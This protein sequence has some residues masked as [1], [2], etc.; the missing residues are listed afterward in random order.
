M[1]QHGVL[2]WAL[3][4][5][6]MAVGAAQ[7]AAQSTE[8]QKLT[9]SDAAANDSFGASVSVSGDTAIVGAWQD[10]CA[11]G[12]NCG[13]AYVYRFDGTSWVEQQKLTPFE[14]RAGDRFGQSVSVDGDTA[15]V[16]ASGYF[17]D[18]LSGSCGAAYV[19]RFDGTSWVEQQ[20]LLADDTSLGDL[21]GLA[22]S[23]SGDT[24]LVGAIQKDAAYVFRFDG[25][26]WVEE[27]K[28]TGSEGSSG[29]NFGWAVSVSGDSAVVGAR[30]D[31]C[32]AGDNCGSVYVYRF[33]GTS[34]DEE[35]K[36][37][38]LNERASDWFGRTVSVDGDTAVVGARF[39]GCA[40]D[41]CPAAY[42]YRHNG[43]TWVEEAKLE[44]SILDSLDL[45]ATSVSVSG[46]TVLV[47]APRADCAAG[48]NCG[49]AYVFWFDG[50]D[51]TEY[52]KL[53]ASDGA[54]SDLLGFAVAVNGETAVLGADE[55]DCAAGEDCGAAYVFAAGRV[56]PCCLGAGVCEMLTSDD[57]AAQGGTFHGVLNALNPDLTCAE[58][59]DTD[60]IADLCDNCPDT[61]NVDQNDCNDDGE[62]DACEADEADQDDDRDGACNGIDPC[63]DDP[64]KSIPGDGPYQAPGECGCG[65]VDPDP[66]TDEDP[67]VCSCC[68][69]PEGCVHDDHCPNDPGKVE[70]G[71]CG[72]GVPDEGDEDG[73]GILNCVDQ[74]RGV[75]DAVFAPECDGAIPTVSEWGL[76]VLAL[77][78]LVVGKVYFGRR[79]QA[80]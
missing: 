35:Q 12:A 14:Q 21:F 76:A 70:A 28:L 17:C 75:D 45:F 66:D 37:N 24:V 56:G 10:D 23:L 33:N 54:E 73:D 61:D 20:I 2:R 22:V 39:T 58:A 26:S 6:I 65:C 9:A 78:L 51:W 15:V 4:A 53:T 31:D 19:F 5:I 1:G 57:C 71:I 59:G 11:M 67:K 18:G 74:C 44:A 52:K 49:A 43:T 38:P 3:R 80:V 42:V 41:P 40:V 7:A 36:L 34:W 77:L 27:Q 16:G 69:R 68:S 64:H 48:N 79:A 25:T 60:G 8:E 55:D 30:W 50:T 63:P 47:G 46:D 72:C 13:A 32:A 62:G 29:D